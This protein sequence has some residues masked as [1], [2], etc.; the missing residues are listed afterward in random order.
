LPSGFALRFDEDLIWLT[1]SQFAQA[2]S[3]GPWTRIRYRVKALLGPALK[4]LRPQRP[5]IVTHGTLYGLSAEAARLA[6]PQKP[7]V[8]TNS[9]GVIAWELS[10]AEFKRMQQR[11]P[12]VPGAASLKTGVIVT[13]SGGQ[14]QIMMLDPQPPGARS[15]QGGLTC[16]ANAKYSAGSIY[17]L[18]G[19]ISTEKVPASAGVSG[20]L[21]TNF[22]F[23]CR[24]HLENAGALLITKRD[25]GSSGGTNYWFLVSPTAVDSR[26]NPIKR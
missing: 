22:A 12:T 18:L 15:A 13:A 19:V 8:A 21:Q 14:A 10:S 9:D 16:D 5:S 6:E 17:L 23:A 4:Y 3:A 7:A 2:S 25:P 1:P 24:S 26:G 20:S 11:L